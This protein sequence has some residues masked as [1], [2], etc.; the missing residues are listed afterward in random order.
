MWYK[1]GTQL[2][3]DA[4]ITIEQRYVPQNSTYH[5]TES[6]LTISDVEL[7]D[8]G[9]YSCIARNRNGTDI[10]Q[11]VLKVLVPGE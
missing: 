8:A 5:F 1:C 7:E 3:S 2:T 4:R 9:N 11:I 6:V 10:H